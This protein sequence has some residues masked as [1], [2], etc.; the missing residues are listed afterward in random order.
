MVTNIDMNRLSDALT[1]L[2]DENLITA[3]KFILYLRDSQ[4]KK[5]ASGKLRSPGS[6]KGEVFMSDDFDEPL[7][8]MEGYM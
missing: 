7:E 1:E 4:D 5:T 2:N 8:D 3:G 6:I